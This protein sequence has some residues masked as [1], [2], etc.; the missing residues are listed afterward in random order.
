MERFGPTAAT[1]A[2][3]VAVV[4]ALIALV[5]WGA[6]LD[7]HVKRLSEEVQKLRDTAAACTEFA[8]RAAEDI[9]GG[10]GYPPDALD[11]IHQYMKEMGCLPNATETK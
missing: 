7:T 3:L 6:N 1:I 8:R 4:A 2:N 9:S 5:Y 10:K 11:K